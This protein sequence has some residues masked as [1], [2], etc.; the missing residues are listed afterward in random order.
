MADSGR[1]GHALLLYENEGCGALP[2]ALAYVQYLNCMD[3]KDGDSCGQC[4]ACRQMSRLVHPDTHFIFPVNSSSK[5]DVSK[6]T[7]ESFLGIWRGLVAENPYFT[8]SELYAALGTEGKSGVIAI[9]EARYILEK[10]SLSSIEDGYKSVLMW[11]PEKMNAETANKLLKIVEEPPEKTVFVFITHNPDRVLPTIFSRCQSYRVLPLPKEELASV[12]TDVFGKDGQAARQQAA[13]SGGSIGVALNAMGDRE[14]YQAFMQIFGGLLKG[15]AGRDLQA[16][17]DAA[18]KMSA[19]GSREKQKAFCIFAGECLRKIFM[20][21]LGMS[22]TAGI[23]PDEA[24]FYSEISAKASDSFC[25][26]AMSLTDRSVMLLE[27]NVNQKMVF[28]DLAGQMFL[29]F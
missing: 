24:V 4:P 14:E 11:L 28:C 29:S 25:R 1:V 21:R 12:L 5:V 9:A 27:R 18:D 17:L 26:K 20:T 22:E 16:V 6:P 2:V 15:C 13:I 10:L 19:I 3:R 8:E 23:S 7:S